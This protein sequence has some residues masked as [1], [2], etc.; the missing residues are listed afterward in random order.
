MQFLRKIIKA[1]D[2]FSIIAKIFIMETDLLSNSFSLG[3]TL[4]DERKKKD[5]PLEKISKSTNISLK[6]LKALENEEFHKI[7]G[8]FY[9]KNYIKSYLKAIDCDEKVFFKT[10]K[11]AF[12][13]VQPAAKEKRTTYYSKVRYSRFKK[14]NVYFSG[15]VFLVLCLTIG[16]MSSPKGPLQGRGEQVFRTCKCILSGA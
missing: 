13:S 14:K 15:L 2:I 12:R 8:E 11:E 6:S 1:V 7:P 4:A 10:H 5:I 3:K 16:A 9:L